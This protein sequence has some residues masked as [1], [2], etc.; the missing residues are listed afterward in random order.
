MLECSDQRT[1]TGSMFRPGTP[2]RLLLQF[3]ECHPALGCTR[4][5]AGSRRE[6]VWA[7]CVVALQQLGLQAS[8]WR[9][10]GHCHH[11]WCTRWI[12][13]MQLMQALC[14][15]GWLGACAG[16]C[17]AL[18][19]VAGALDTV[20]RRQPGDTHQQ[21]ALRAHAHNRSLTC[22]ASIQ[23]P[24]QP[25]M[26]SRACHR[27]CRGCRRPPWAAVLWHPPPR[28]RR[29]GRVCQV[30]AGAGLGLLGA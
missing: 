21:R 6:P 26:L 7:L 25:R 5:T 9:S 30:R 28:V 27:C 13:W 8:A 1:V 12:T 3:N 2:S 20:S 10:A 4:G 22:T 15:L 24:V 16:I 11:I 17:T 18:N 23:Y 29:A 14:S 19:S